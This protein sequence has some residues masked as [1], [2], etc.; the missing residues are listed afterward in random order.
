MNLN[1]IINK[2]RTYQKSDGILIMNA[3]YDLGQI[4]LS[5]SIDLKKLR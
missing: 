2:Q 1:K 3:Y 4:Y 5:R